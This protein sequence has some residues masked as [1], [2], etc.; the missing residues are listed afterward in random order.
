MATADQIVNLAKS[1]LHGTRESVVKACRDM[2]QHEKPESSLRRRL[3]VLLNR[4][5][6]RGI[7]QATELPMDIKSL[8]LQVAPSHAL[9]ETLLP[10]EVKDQVRIF[11]N[12]RK[13]KKALNS[14]GLLAPHK[15]LLDGP[16]GN[17]KTTLAGAI[18]KELDLPFYV[19]DYSKLI[20][21]HLGETGGKL[22]KVFNFLSEKD[23]ILFMDE[24]EAVLTERSAEGNHDVAEIARVVSTL[25]LEIDWLPDNVVLVGATNHREMLDRAVVRRFDHHWK[26]PKPSDD[27]CAEWIAVFAKKYCSIPIEENRDA[28]NET[29]PFHSL[30]DL[31]RAAQSWCRQWVIDQ[32]VSTHKSKELPCN[33]E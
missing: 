10:K 7:I 8:L 29:G 2:A 25:L 22:A 1:A 12:E 28:I 16:P 31:N 3:E 27:M 21:S 26:L 19:L 20:S 9:N 13:Y 30:S 23:C 11:L 15:L 6:R 33:P 17:G 4:P 18:A 24:M 32:E 14:K 5:D